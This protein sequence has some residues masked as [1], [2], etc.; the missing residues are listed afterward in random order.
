MKAVICYM[1]TILGITLAMPCSAE[2]TFEECVKSLGAGMYN[3]YLETFCGFKGGVSNELKRIYSE[4]GC[5]STVPQEVVDSLSKKVTKDSSAR[6]KSLGESKFCAGNKEN[7]YSLNKATPL[8]QT[9]KA[10]NLP[11]FKK[12]ESYSSVRA[13]M[14][15]AG[16]EPFHAP[17][18]D[19]CAEGDKRCE[20]RPE[21]E[22]CVGTGLANC[23]FLWRKNGK[24]TAICTVGEDTAVYD[25]ICSYP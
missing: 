23:K 10:N 2:V 24:I 16:W 1:V 7:Y 22:S 13:K 4:G 14:L 25:G 21:M 17:D 9:A 11:Q 6:M 19:E 20:G 15:K 8:K 3:Q 5:R 12:K 18:A